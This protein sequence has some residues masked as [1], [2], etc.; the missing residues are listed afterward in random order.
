[1]TV[2]AESLYMNGRI[3]FVD[4]VAKT[5]VERHASE[6]GS[7]IFGISGKWGEG[8]TY[9][10]NDLRETLEKTIESDGSSF[11]VVEVNP[12]KFSLDRIAFLRNFLRIMFSECKRKTQR[13]LKSL[14]VDTSENR[15]HRVRFAI[16]V[17][18][19]ATLCLLLINDAFLRFVRDIP[20]RFQFSLT[21]LLL[22]VVLAAVQSVVTVQRT[23]HAI[24]TLDKF[25]ELLKIALKDFNSAKKKIVVFVDDLDRVTPTM[26]RDVLDNLR[27]FFDKKEIT[28]VVTGDHS[29]LEGYLG[30]SLLPDDPIPAAQLEEGRRFMKKIFDVYW[31]LPPPIKRQ[32][33]EFIDDQFRL[34]EKNLAEVFPKDDDKR[35]FASYLEKYF[36]SNYR[37]IIRFLDTVLF[38]FQIVSIKANDSDRQQ[39]SYFAEMLSHPLLVVRILAIQELCAPL[40]DRMLREVSILKE[41]EYAVEKKDTSKINQILD[42]D[43][44][45]LSLNQL[46]P[47]QRTF[48]EKFIYEEP[49]FYK[50]S[51]LQVLSLQP[52]LS[53]AADVSFGDQRGP[54]SEDFIATLVLG[55]PKALKNDLISM[56]EEK[57]RDA[58]NT[59]ASRLTAEVSV[60]EKLDLVKTLLVALSDSDTDLPFHT[61]YADMLATFEFDFINSAESGSRLEVL[62]LLI[63]WIERVGDDSLMAKFENKISLNEISDIDALAT[64]EDGPLRS[65]VVAKWLV[66]SYPTQK[67]NVLAA[68]VVHF[69]RLKIEVVRKQVGTIADT[70]VNDVIQESDSLLRESRLILLNE[71]T[72]NGADKLKSKILDQVSNF[73]QVNIAWILEQA[74]VEN[75]LWTED[76][77]HSKV[78]D[79]ISVYESLDQLLQGLRFATD[80]QIETSD[81][82]WWL[83]VSNRIDSIIENLPALIDDG[84]LKAFAPPKDV[85]VQL[86]DAMFEKIKS[87]SSSEQTVLLPYLTKDKWLWSNLKKYPIPTK[88]REIKNFKNNEVMAAKSALVESWKRK[89]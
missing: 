44:N 16:Y 75:K 33:Q 32:L 19:L 41:I 59:F 37:Q 63:D 11:K 24:V 25:D 72:S 85:A 4:V 87:L 46:S 5:I 43:P 73:D 9:F 42:Q 15:I 67:P 68:M 20:P 29:V 1:M 71:Y 23:S 70:L 2:V 35:A 84:S 8:K 18:I 65:Y 58:A 56:G 54:S 38:N 83:L 40:F 57:T 12:W 30:R 36:E 61:T 74:K 51:R 28:F 14:D 49:R 17:G 27:T 26:A 76:E 79:K 88:T 3:P 45:G 39:A 6:N 22:P 50:D 81:A 82:I 47:N 66:E 10:L 7:F 34:K 62:N 21:V 78:L 86:M 13:K 80:N 52:Y 77:I 55:D 60:I 53:L 69:P 31:R 64:I 89:I 48:I